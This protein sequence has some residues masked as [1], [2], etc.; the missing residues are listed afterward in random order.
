V[1]RSGVQ[2]VSDSDENDP[3]K[4]ADVAVVAIFKVAITV[5]KG[6]DA[7]FES[8]IDAIP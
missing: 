6:P 7:A 3:D 2:T 4:L 1:K 8:L 5:A